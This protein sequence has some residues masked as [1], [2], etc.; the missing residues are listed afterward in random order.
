ML[1]PMWTSCTVWGGGGGGGGK[2]NYRMPVEHRLAID[3]EFDVKPN[4][5]STHTTGA[6]T[7]GRPNMSQVSHSIVLPHTVGTG[8]S[9]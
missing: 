9:V 8:G 7:S 4:V 1:N 2:T 5:D 3:L 6:K